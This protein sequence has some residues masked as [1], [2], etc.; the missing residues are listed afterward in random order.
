MDHFETYADAGNAC[1]AVE[2]AME[3]KQAEIDVLADALNEVGLSS[4]DNWAEALADFAY[5]PTAPDRSPERS[6]VYALKA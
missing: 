6:L 4:L 1:L 2:E 5:W 3:R